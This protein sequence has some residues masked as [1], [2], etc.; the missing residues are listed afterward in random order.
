MVNSGNR[1]SAEKNIQVYNTEA[2][3]SMETVFYKCLQLRYEN[4][5]LSNVYVM[6]IATHQGPSLLWLLSSPKC[7]KSTIHRFYF[8]V[9]HLIHQG[10]LG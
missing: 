7:W 9:K 4:W 3:L 8:L 5:T 2:D 6:K 10:N 1:L